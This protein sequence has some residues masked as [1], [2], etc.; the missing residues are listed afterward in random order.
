MERVDFEENGQQTTEALDIWEEPFQSCLSV[1]YASFSGSSTFKNSK[2]SY[3]GMLTVD[4]FPKD[5][6]KSLTPVIQ[7]NQEEVGRRSIPLT[8]DDSISESMDESSTCP[9]GPP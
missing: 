5:K 7:Y 6:A 2:I 8:Y 4:N 3:E 1:P 9:R